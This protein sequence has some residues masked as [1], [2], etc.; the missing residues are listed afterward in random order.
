MKV[1]YQFSYKHFFQICMLF[2]N[3]HMVHQQYDHIYIYSFLNIL[4]MSVDTYRRNIT[5]TELTLKS[6]VLLVKLTI[7]INTFLLQLLLVC[8]MIIIL[9]NNF[10]KKYLYKN[11]ASFI[12][13][14]E[15]KSNKTFRKVKRSRE[16]FCNVGTLKTFPFLRSTYLSIKFIKHCQNFFYIL[17]HRENTE[18]INKAKY[19]CHGGRNFKAFFSAYPNKKMV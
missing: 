5:C 16:H 1:S 9:C 18:A 17:R 12:P 11:Y 2:I 10:T 13:L 4:C 8:F 19:A 7:Y 15:W 3:I 6:S 14:H